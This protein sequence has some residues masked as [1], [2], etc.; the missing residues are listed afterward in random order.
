[1][2][3]A[4]LQWQSTVGLVLAALAVVYLIVVLIFPE[5]F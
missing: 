5:R 4:F 2:T 3:L 1:M